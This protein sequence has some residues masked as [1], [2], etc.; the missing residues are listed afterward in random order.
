MAEIEHFVQEDKK[1]HPK[2][3]N[4]ANLRL[5]LFPVENQLGD[6]KLVRRRP[7]CHPIRSCLKCDAGYPNPR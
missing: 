1:D 7:P 5:N 4:V 6:G 2:F 3:A